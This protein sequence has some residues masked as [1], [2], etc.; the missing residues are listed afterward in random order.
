MKTSH[1]GVIAPPAPPR[2]AFDLIVVGGGIMG[3]WVARDAAARG[4]RVAV[5]EQGDVASGTSSRTSKLVHE[6]G[7]ASCRE[8]V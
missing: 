7:R 1:D 2:D 8:R 5:F 4:M 6:I 3:A